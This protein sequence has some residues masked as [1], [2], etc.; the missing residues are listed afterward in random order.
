MYSPTSDQ[1][2]RLDIILQTQVYSPTAN[3]DLQSIDYDATTANEQFTVYIRLV[4][5][6]QNIL[7]YW[8]KPNGENDY[9]YISA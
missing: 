7:Y 6:D 4:D 5:K 3:W 9:G 2:V 8:I 1:I